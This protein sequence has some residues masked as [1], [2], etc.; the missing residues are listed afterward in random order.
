MG[1]SW[2]KGPKM[3]QK[4]TKIEQ[5][6]QNWSRNATQSHVF[7]AWKRKRG[8]G[9]WAQPTGYIYSM[10]QLGGRARQAEKKNGLLPR[11]CWR[12]GAYPAKEKVETPTE[13]GGGGIESQGEITTNLV[14]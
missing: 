11:S 9:V 2:E 6:M 4:G 8:G 13:K 3:V 14:H 10:S 5:I 7:F 12:L 1:R